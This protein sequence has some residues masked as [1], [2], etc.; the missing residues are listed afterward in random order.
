MTMNPLFSDKE[1]LKPFEGTVAWRLAGKNHR[2]QAFNTGTDF[3]L[4]IEGPLE[5][6]TPELGDL[7]GGL[8]IPF[9]VLRRESVFPK[10]MPHG[11]S[12]PDFLYARKEDDHV[13]LFALDAKRPEG[14][15][16]KMHI[17]GAQISAW[18][19]HNLILTNEYVRR[20]LEKAAEFFN[21]K[22]DDVVFTEGFIIGGGREASTLDRYIQQSPELPGNTTLQFS[23]EGVKVVEGSTIV[24]S[25][26]DCLLLAEVV[27]REQLKQWKRSLL[28]RKVRYP[29][30]VEIIR[31]WDESPQHSLLYT[32]E[33]GLLIYTDTRLRHLQE[34]EKRIRELSSEGGRKEDTIRRLQEIIEK[35]IRH[36][37]R[38]LLRLEKQYAITEQQLRAEE[39]WQ[40]RKAE[41]WP[42][43]F[44]SLLARNP[45]YHARWPGEV[46]LNEKSLQRVYNERSWLKIDIE[47]EQLSRE[48]I[49]EMTR[50][51]LRGVQYQRRARGA[52]L[53]G[54]SQAAISQARQEVLEQEELAILHRII[55]EKIADLE[56]RQPARGAPQTERDLTTL[57][58]RVQK[59][60]NKGLRVRKEE[61]RERR[62]HYQREQEQIEGLFDDVRTGAPHSQVRALNRLGQTGLF[63]LDHILNAPHFDKESIVDIR[64]FA[65]DILENSEDYRAVL[66][67]GHHLPAWLDTYRRFLRQEAGMK[68]D[69]EVTNLAQEQEYL[70]ER[71]RRDAQNLI[72]VSE[73]YLSALQTPSPIA[74]NRAAYKREL[75]RL[76]KEEQARL[77]EF[78]KLQEREE[79]DHP[80][81]ATDLNDIVQKQASELRELL[82][83]QRE[84]RYGRLRNRKSRFQQSFE[85]LERTKN[86]VKQPRIREYYLDLNHQSPFVVRVQVIPYIPF[87]SSPHPD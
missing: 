87:T 40:R 75:S 77:S 28:K 36:S 18:N 13:T 86:L 16:D 76:K 2:L 54:D 85:N 38:R 25:L 50:R 14:E 5:K 49:V 41:K 45:L 82:R 44:A 70:L 27:P 35:E 79:I 61:D 9:D 74:L 7:H 3:Y 39:E 10:G 56:D 11:L 34:I 80:R 69:A 51:Q 43:Q 81:R 60:Y 55:N 84:R 52:R 58:Q 47:R 1:R 66:K 19:I 62:A 53:S 31:G 73:A 23:E 4:T 32:P 22:P 17:S 24:N 33:S 12:T 68:G 57:V 29:L 15:L 26:E 20:V 64:S 67:S 8:I 59:A 21:T 83:R 78:R 48:R 63:S 46:Q 30:N 72:R 6:E 65:E 71:L 42:A 37:R